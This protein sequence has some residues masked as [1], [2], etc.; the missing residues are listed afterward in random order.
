MDAIKKGFD[1]RRFSIRDAISSTKDVPF[2]HVEHR[3]AAIRTTT[4]DRCKKLTIKAALIVSAVCL[5]FSVLGLAFADEYTFD[6]SEIAKCLTIEAST[7]RSNLFSTG[8]TGTLLSTCSTSTVRNKDDTLAEY[9]GTLQLDGSFEKGI[10]RLFVRTNTAYQ[11]SYLGSSL[12]TTLYEGYLSLKSSP[13]L[14]IDAGKN[15]EVG[16]RLRMEPRGIHRQT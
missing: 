6:T 1:L 4:D 10:S 3:I 7:Q 8:W 13:S 11:N 5:L 2:L 15:L 9:D 12:N 14:T 16:Q